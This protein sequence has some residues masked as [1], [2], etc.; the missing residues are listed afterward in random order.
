MAQDVPP[1]AKG[2]Y[3]KIVQFFQGV[4]NAMKI[5]G[6]NKAADIF[7]DIEAGKVGARTRGEIRTLR[8]LDQAG[9]GQA[10]VVT[11]YEDDAETP[12]GPVVETNLKPST[13]RPLAF[14]PR[15][16]PTT[17]PPTCTPTTPTTPVIPTTPV[18]QGKNP[19]IKFKNPY[20]YNYL[21][22]YYSEFNGGDFSDY[23][24]FR[25]FFSAN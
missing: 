12:T 21:V 25:D 23:Q 15:A 17:T 18:P 16:T 6:Y 13:I 3:N 20:A 14:D 7:Q 4:G 11:D 2:I 8:D 1:K 5:S 22:R 9:R 19:P 24:V 10:Q